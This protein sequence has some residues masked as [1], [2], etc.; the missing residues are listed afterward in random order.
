MQH[1]ISLNGTWSLSYAEGRSRSVPLFLEQPHA[2][3]EWSVTAQVPEAVQQTLA[4]EGV[5][6]SPYAGTGT[7]A[8]YKELG[9]GIPTVNLERAGNEVIIT[10]DLLAWGVCLDVDG[11]VPLEENSVTVVP[12]LP[13][14]I[15]WKDEFGK[16]RVVAVGNELVRR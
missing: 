13:Y 9:L 7:L 6:P 4:R 11:E 8:A 12:G 2:E 5:L 15:G 16:P 1:E 14:P 10:S 3:P